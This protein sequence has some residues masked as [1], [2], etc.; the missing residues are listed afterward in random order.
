[1][2]T[3]KKKKQVVML[4][5]EKESKLFRKNHNTLEYNKNPPLHGVK[6]LN[7]KYQHIYI[8]SDESIK[9]LLK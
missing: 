3:V 7:W 9:D 8:L 4:P 2:T 6:D 1:M 5:T